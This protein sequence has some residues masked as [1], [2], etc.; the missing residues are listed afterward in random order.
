M[1][2][3]AISLNENLN[4]RPKRI[5]VCDALPEAE[6][7]P[8]KE[9]G[10]Q[11]SFNPAISAEELNQVVG[12]YDVLL[13]RSRT[14]VT[15]Q[16]LERSKLKLIVRAGVGLD[17]ID[18]EAARQRNIS[19]LNTPDANTN[20]AAEMTIGLMFAVAR[21]IPQADREL[22]EG[23]WVPVKHLGFEL[24]GKTLGI[25]GFGNIGQEV[26]KKAYGL[27][28]KPITFDPKK[29]VKTGEGLGVPFVG[30]KELL[31]R[32]DIIS[33]HVP[34]LPSTINLINES[35]LEL[36]KRDAIL[37]N[38]SRGGIV[39]EEAVLDALDMQKL[40]GAGF[41]VYEN[42]PEVNPRLKLHE[43]VV[44]TPHLGASTREAQVRVVREAIDRII[45]YFEANNS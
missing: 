27:S 19:V 3:S 9:S 18:I 16:V 36:V 30:F 43:R 44:L 35:T 38:A 40:G 32:S 41:D 2:E 21:Q 20:S 4:D 17:N 10:Y 22:R 14:K 1:K 23:M 33:L 31:T 12:D 37:I 11:V 45:N 28:M 42:E 7:D 13:V 39:D 26:A 29:D 6:L 25:V 15:T 5:L 8:L 24:R 34:L